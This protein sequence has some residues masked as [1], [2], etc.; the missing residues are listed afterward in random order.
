MLVQEVMAAITMSP[1]LILKSAPATFASMGFSLLVFSLNALV[2]LLAEFV[3]RTLSCGL[4][5][6]DIPVSYT[7]LTLPTKRIV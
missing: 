3:N 4:L 5:G 6:P 2:K 7:H 1:S